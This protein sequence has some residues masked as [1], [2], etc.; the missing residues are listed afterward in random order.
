MA[1]VVL[2]HE[3]AEVFVVANG[4]RAGRT[5]PL[6]T[7]RGRTPHI[8]ASSPGRGGVGVTDPREVSDVA[9]PVSTVPGPQPRRS[10]DGP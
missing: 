3:V 2:V 8:G 4:V 7:P 10:D 9:S 5:R 1:A 6:A